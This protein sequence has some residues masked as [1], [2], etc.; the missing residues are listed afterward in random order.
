M[1]PIGDR[2]DSTPRRPLRHAVVI[3]GGIAGLLA[4][5]VLSDRFER[6][7]LL[8]RHSLARAPAPAPRR[9]VP[10]GAHVHVLLARGLA[11]AEGLF[12][13]LAEELRAAGAVQLNSGRDLRWHHSGGWRARY[14]SGLDFLSMS[15]PLFEAAIAGRVRALPNLALR[16]GVRA[17][18]LRGDRGGAVTGLRVR[19]PDGGG[20]EEIGADLVVDAAGRG[21]ATPRWLAEQG[22]EA[23]PAEILPA[24]VA[25]A[26]CLFRPSGP[27]PRL[28]GVAVGGAPARRNGA[29]FPIEGGRWLATLVGFFDEP[30][31]RDH[32]A[33]LAFARSLAVP[34]IHEALRGLEPLSGIA[35]HA[36]AGS[37]RRR[38]DRLERLPAGLVALG[39]AVCSLNPVYGQG[40]TVGAIEAEAL[41]RALARAG[42]EGGLGPEFGR[43][44]FRGV[45]PVVDTAWAGVSLEDL[46]FPELAARRSVRLELLQWY[47]RRVHRATHRSAPVTEWFYRV[48]NFLDPPA[49]LFRPGVAAAALFGGTA[50]RWPR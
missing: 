31:P 43:L 41:G 45:A 46:S 22:F 39:D 4:A 17:E 24:R 9:G 30:M 40:M 29:L 37:L 32:D 34:D 19:S 5:R 14:D 1:I 13:G 7:T 15:R 23:P 11:V 2:P 3:G 6:V 25:Y 35:H 33:F 28:R 10:Q 26:S 44:W 20:A 18:G 8:E 48:V 50:R 12:P 49:S 47:M 21:S 38:Y 16:E 27:V 42:R 36:F